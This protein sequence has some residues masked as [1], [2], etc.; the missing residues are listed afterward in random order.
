[1]AAVKIGQIVATF[2]D[3][4]GKRNRLKFNVAADGTANALDSAIPTGA[5]TPVINSAQKISKCKYIKTTLVLPM[6]RQD[7]SGKTDPVAGSSVFRE[8]YLEFISALGDANRA[9]FARIW[10]PSPLA[11]KL[12][13]NKTTFDKTNT[14]VA[15]LINAVKTNVLSM[16]GRALVSDGDTKV[17][18]RITR[19]GR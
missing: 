12:G 6:G 3:A 11:S 19:K 13:G 8:G 17:R 16:D 14:D 2:A 18:E 10:V 1:M 7:Y 15:A 4:A 9:T 5:A